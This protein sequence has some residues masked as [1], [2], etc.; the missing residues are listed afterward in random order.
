MKILVLNGSPRP[1]GNTAA[2]VNAFKTGAEKNG[3]EVV[4]MNVASMNIKGCLGCEFCHTK[5]QGACVQKD[6]MQNV[7]PEIASAD[8][9]IFASPVYYFGLTGQMETAIS[10]FYA[11]VKPAKAKKFG[12]IISSGSP[13]V[14]AGI[15]A[16]FQGIVS[17]WEGEN[18]GVREFAGE[19]NTKESTFANVMAFGESIK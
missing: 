16:Q 15:E 2:L 5:G 19:E 14:Y 1:K 17:F 3:N 13:N 4:V 6:D 12:M 7:Y 10:R 18:I 8:V 11:P 9:I